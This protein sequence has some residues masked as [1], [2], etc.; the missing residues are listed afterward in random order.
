MGK[1]SRL[2]E[3]RYFGDDAPL[4]TK[5]YLYITYKKVDV[6]ITQLNPL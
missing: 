5:R 2:V 6:N 1:S 4:K 3:V